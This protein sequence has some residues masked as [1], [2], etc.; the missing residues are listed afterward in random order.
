M[1]LGVASSDSQAN[2]EA[3]PM[4]Q[5]YLWLWLTADPD[6]IVYANA[7]DLD[8]LIPKFSIFTR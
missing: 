7:A 1:S 5:L 6:T 8:W 4:V 2:L 3:F